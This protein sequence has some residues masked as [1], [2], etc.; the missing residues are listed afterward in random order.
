[1]FEIF[2][3]V[4]HIPERF[5]GQLSIKNA[6]DKIPIGHLPAHPWQFSLQPDDLL[7]NLTPILN[8]E[9]LHFDHGLK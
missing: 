4:L 1:M 5:G 9:R 6:I 3:I 2:N 7:H 8:P